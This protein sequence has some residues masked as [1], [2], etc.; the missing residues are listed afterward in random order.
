MLEAYMKSVWWDT[1]FAETKNA[2]VVSAKSLCSLY[3][4]WNAWEPQSITR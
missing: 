2:D 3:Y 4:E 1:P